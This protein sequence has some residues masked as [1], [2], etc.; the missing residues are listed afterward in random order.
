[1]S[2]PER[3]KWHFPNRATP[4]GS[5]AYYSVRFAPR[6]LRHDLAALIAWHRQ[7]RAILDEVSDPGVAQLKLQWWRDELNRTYAGEPRHPL[8][9]VL[10][11]IVEKRSLP[12]APFL[13]IAEQVEAGILRRQPADEAALIAGCERDYGALF[14]LMTRCH[15]IDDPDRLEAARTLGTF[16]ALVYIIRDSG[17]LAR[18]GRLPLPTE[19]LREHGLS[20]QALAQQSHRARLPELL[21]RTACQARD[22]LEQARVIGSLPAFARVRTRVLETLLREIEDMAFDVADQRIEL[23]ALRKLWLS[24]QESLRNP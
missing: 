12:S 3:D 13:Q 16:C 21:P 20:T 22:L 17:A 9:V 19:Q 7:V 6:R 18:Q 4:P 15:A 24:W 5:S 10:H 1:M 11:G 14:D 2:G 8:S 23:T